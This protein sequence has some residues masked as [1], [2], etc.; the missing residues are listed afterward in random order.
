MVG[1]AG[2]NNKFAKKKDGWKEA[3]K[4]GG[5]RNKVEKIGKTLRM[6]SKTWP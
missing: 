2:S 1:M 5:K 4:N 6:K 3:K